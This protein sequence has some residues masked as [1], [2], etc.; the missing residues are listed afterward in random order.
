[1]HKWN[2]CFIKFCFLSRSQ[3]YLYFSGKQDQKIEMTRAMTNE[4]KKD[5]KGFLP[6]M[7]GFF[8]S[9]VCKCP[10]RRGCTK[11]CQDKAKRLFFCFFVYLFFVWFF[12]GN[13]FLLSPL[14]SCPLAP[15]LLLQVHSE[16]AIRAAAWVRAASQS[17]SVFD[18]Q[19]KEECFAQCSPTARH[20]GR[21]CAVLSKN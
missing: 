16:S 19:T 2:L 6:Y 7:T 21:I 10:C 13:F 12:V 11:K 17:S 5:K 3:L 1:M 20:Y 9:L 15:T 8:Q 18:R 14:P 4:K